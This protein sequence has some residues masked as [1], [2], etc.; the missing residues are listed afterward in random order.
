MSVKFFCD[1]CGSESQVRRIFLTFKIDVRGDQPAGFEPEQD[2]FYS[3]DLCPPC[4]SRRLEPVLKALGDL[5]KYR[6]C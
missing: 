2:A 1:D 3:C 6:E 5:S 4:R